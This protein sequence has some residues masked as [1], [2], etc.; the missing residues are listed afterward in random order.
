MRIPGPRR[1]VIAHIDGDEIDTRLDQ[2]AGQKACWHQLL[3]IR[4]RLSAGSR[5][6]SK[7]SGPADRRRRSGPPVARIVERLHRARPIEVAIRADRNGHAVPTRSIRCLV[8]P[9]GRLNTLPTFLALNGSYCLPNQP[10]QATCPDPAC[11]ARHRGAWS[12]Y[13]ARD[14]ATSERNGRIYIRF[15]VQSRLGLRFARLHHLVRFMIRE[16]RIDRANDRERSIIAACFGKYSQTPRRERRGSLA[17]G[18]RIS[19]GHR[20]STSHVSIWLGPP[21]IHSR[22]TLF[23]SGVDRPALAAALR[24]RNKPG[25]L[26]PADPR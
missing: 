10:P 1:T 16:P 12:D 23:L 2:P 24:A 11:S 3:A 19:A 5:D 18:P 15:A 4:S 20:A 14:S 13:S 17:N 9:A 6:R 8:Q 26:S 21:V 7:I 22:I 25:R